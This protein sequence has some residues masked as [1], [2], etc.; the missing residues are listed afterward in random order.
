[1]RRGSINTALAPTSLVLGAAALALTLSLSLL[2]S[3]DSAQPVEF[4]RISATVIP[5]DGPR[6]ALCLLHAETPRQIQRGLMGVTDR[7]LGGC[8]GMAFT[9]SADTTEPFWMRDTP[10]PLSIAYFDAKGR[11][12]STAD[13]KPCGD[14][15]RCPLYPPAREYRLAVEAPRGQLPGLG[16]VPGAR[17]VLGERGCD[18]GPRLTRTAGA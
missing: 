11:L 4:G 9:F 15:P 10:L 8:D 14:H 3:D 18:P 2:R 13:M 1:M 7:T 12:V 5:P 17:L 6:L 16:I